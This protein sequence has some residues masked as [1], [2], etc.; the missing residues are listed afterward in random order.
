M[1]NLALLKLKSSSSHDK[2][3]AGFTI[4]EILIV[5]VIAGIL[6]AVAAPSWLA[7]INRQR[8]NTTQDQALR[9]MREAQET[10]N[11]SNQRW[12]VSF[13]QN[14]DRV[15]WAVH[16]VAGDSGDDC[17]PDDAPWNDFESTIRIDTSNTNL[18]PS[19]CPISEWRV[20]FDLKGRVRDTTGE[21]GMGRITFVT[22]NS[23]QAKRCVI[24]STLLGSMRT[25]QD[26]GCVLT[27]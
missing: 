5:L 27:P 11:R 16:P 10:A 26:D 12:Q 2:E 21:F 18:G 24:V 22:S 19:I 7:F 17:I 13:R 9:A 23:T 6:A 25:D 1:K 4:F 14:E 20:Q 8:L 3:R 15:Q